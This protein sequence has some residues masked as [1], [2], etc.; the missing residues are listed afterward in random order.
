MFADLEAANNLYAKSPVFAK[1]SIDLMYGGNMTPVAE[2]QQ[3][4][5]SA[6][7]HARERTRAEMGADTKSPRLCPTPA[8]TQ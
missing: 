3:F 6:I 5:V 1:P 8:S 2:I 7:A 4:T